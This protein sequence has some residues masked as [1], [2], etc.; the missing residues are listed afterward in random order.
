[1]SIRSNAG[2]WRRK[3]WYSSSVHS[4][5][6][7]STPGPV[8][9]APIEQDDLPAGGE[10]GDVALEV[11]LGLLPIARNGKGGDPAPPGVEVLGDALDH[12]TLARGV[13]TLDHDDD[14]L[15]F[16][17]DPLL[18][19]HQLLLEPEER[20]V[21]DVVLAM[22]PSC[23]G[24]RSPYATHRKETGIRPAVVL[25]R[26]GWWVEHRQLGSNGASGPFRPGDGGSGGLGADLPQPPS[27]NPNSF[28]VRGC[29]PAGPTA[30]GLALDRDDGCNGG[31]G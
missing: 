19:H 17:P 13:S 25:V 29:G 18:H 15:A 2:H 23:R 8:V 7:R 28:L 9:P 30:Q 11:P 27:S 14:A 16:V 5:M 6:T 26:G 4:P 24:G 12:S 10:M 31:Q 21:V 3:R 1:M 20:L 22:A